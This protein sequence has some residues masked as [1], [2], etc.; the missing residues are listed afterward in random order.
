MARKQQVHV[1]AHRALCG[2]EREAVPPG[3]RAHGSAELRRRRRRGLRS[4]AGAVSRLTALLSLLLSQHSLTHCSTAA[5]AHLQERSGP[6]KARFRSSPLRPPDQSSYGAGSRITPLCLLRKPDHVRTSPACYM[7][8]RAAELCGGRRVPAHRGGPREHPGG[9][10]GAGPGARAP[11]HA[12][13]PVLGPPRAVSGLGMSPGWPSEKGLR[14]AVNVVDCCCGACQARACRS[15]VVASSTQSGLELVLVQAVPGSFEG[16]VG[17]WANPLETLVHRAAGSWRRRWRRCWAC[18]TCGATRARRRAASASCCGPATCWT[19]GARHA[20]TILRTGCSLPA[21]RSHVTRFA[22]LQVVILTVLS[23]RF[24]LYEHCWL[25]IM[26]SCM[27]A[28]TVSCW[29]CL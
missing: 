9:G 12:P 11:A 10:G 16:R 13:V 14:H 15:P 26:P 20:L 6:G 5:S 28:A 29:A 25:Q 19:P 4:N 1:L 27:Q 8:C 23:M 22:A 3:I 24:R 18:S 7:S 21:V 17:P 2:P